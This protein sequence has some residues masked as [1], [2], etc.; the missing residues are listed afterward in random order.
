MSTIYQNG[1]KSWGQEYDEDDG[2]VLIKYWC[3]VF[4]DNFFY[5]GRYTK[6]S[7][8]YSDFENGRLILASAFERNLRCF[9]SIN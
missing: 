3:I 9:I 2:N 6:W 4:G 5:N 7:T 1:V 8:D